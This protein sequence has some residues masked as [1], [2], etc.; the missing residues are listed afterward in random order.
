MNDFIKRTREDGF[1][2]W[3]NPNYD[4]VKAAA[5]AYEKATHD[6]ITLSAEQIA[7][8]QL[9]CLRNMRD[10][11][12]RLP[13]LVS[14]NIRYIFKIVYSFVYSYSNTYTLH[15]NLEHNALA[16]P[17]NHKTFVNCADNYNHYNGAKI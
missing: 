7:A 9:L 11:N 17:M 2:E 4:E 3:V 6:P 14:K 13:K 10:K 8:D 16:N 1:I 15:P 5:E 12:V